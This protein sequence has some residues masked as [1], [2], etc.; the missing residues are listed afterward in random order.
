MHKMKKILYILFAMAFALCSCTEEIDLQDTT[1]KEC[2]KLTIFNSPMTKAD[3]G[4]DYERNLTHLDVFFYV[5]GQTDS[6]CVYYQRV[7]DSK[8]LTGAAEIPFYVVEEQINQIFPNGNTCDVLVIANLP[9]GIRPVLS[10]GVTKARFGT[11]NVGTEYNRL[12]ALVLE[13]GNG[14]DD[15]GQNFIMAGFDGNVRKDGNNNASGTV[16]LVRAASKITITV[17]IPEQ[18]VLNASEDSEEIT[19][20]PV[21]LDDQGNV[22]FKTAL[23]N[24]VKYGYVYPAGMVDS[25]MSVITDERYFDTDKLGYTK[26]KEIPADGA[27]GVKKYQYTCEVPFY[28]YSSSWQKGDEHAVHLTLEIPWKRVGENL[29]NTYYYQILVNAGGRRLDPNHWYDLY[30]NVGVIGS[31]VESKPVDLDDMTV[32]V[33]DWTTEPDPEDT[34]GGDR[35]EDVQIEQYTYLNVPQKRIEMNNTTTGKVSFEASH[36]V[37]WALEWPTGTGASDIISTFDQMEREYNT[38]G[39]SA[40]Y[41]NCAGTPTVNSLSSFIQSDDK[42]DFVLSASG[43][44]ITF[45]YPKGEIDEYNEKQDANADKYNVYSPVYIHLKIW[46]DINNDNKITEELKEDEYVEYIT[47]VYYPA[48]YI[49][50]DLS[51]PYS[52]YVNNVQHSNQNTDYTITSGNTTHNLGHVPG[53]SGSWGTKDSYMY[54][55]TVTSFNGTETFK[56]PNGTYYP[57]I[58]GDPRMRI[59]DI[60][61]DNNNQYNVSEQWVEAD[62]ISFDSNGNVVKDADGNIE[63]IKRTLKYYYPTES[64]GNAFQIVSPKFKIVSFHSSGWGQISPNGAKMRCATFQED[65]YPAGRWRLPTAAEVMFVIDLQDAG[66]ISNIF[67]GSSQYY[68]ASENGTKRYKISNPNTGGTRTWSSASTGSVRCVYDEWYWGAEREANV[69]PSYNPNYNNGGLDNNANHSNNHYLFTWG[70]KQIWDENGN[71]L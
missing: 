22:P 39:L 64:E 1:G 31:T 53:V 57:Y 70:D 51:N 23:H 5:E 25:D 54:T 52:I 27:T 12:S 11:G 45:T 41:V 30:V 66:V 65:G 7:T 24:G 10:D 29:Y 35:Y 46:L 47:F 37:K 67:H 48:M 2:I 3:A 61:M 26:V 59:S 36:T 71:P 8:Y 20:V 32:Y 16:K 56:A 13:K 63:Y 21:L 69:N 14:Y 60:E 44:A 4:P 43:Q 40:Y 42:K 19:M 17:N 62:A 38:S 50:P 28:S 55:V 6:P 58:I 33:L 15:V 18:I 68:C 34:A 49:T 9:D